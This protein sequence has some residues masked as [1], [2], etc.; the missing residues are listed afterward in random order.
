[1]SV[2]TW[3]FTPFTWTAAAI[4]VVRAGARSARLCQSLE[5]ALMGV[6]RGPPHAGA[7]GSR[8]G[9]ARALCHRAVLVCAWSTVPERPSVPC[10]GSV[11]A[12]L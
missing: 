4:H 5:G 9:F 1:M 6:P 11:S 2:L 10:S 8:R 12:R 7:G 3:L